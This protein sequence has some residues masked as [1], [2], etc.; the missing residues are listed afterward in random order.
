[1]KYAFITGGGR[2]LG[3]GFVEYLSRNGYYVF[4]GV[5]TIKPEYKN[6]DLVE[7]VKCNVGDDQS[8]TSCVNQVKTKTVNLN[9]IVNNAGIN[10]DSATDGHK[11]QVCTL[12]QLKR[13]KLLSMMNINAIS[14]LMVVQAFHDLLMGSPS[15]VI[16][17]S[18]DRASYHDEYDNPT[19]NYGYRASKA[20]QNMFTF[21]ST[22]DLPPNVKIFAVHPGNVKTDMNPGGSQQPVNQAEKIMTITTEWKD[23]YNGKFMRWDG[24]YYPL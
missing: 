5:Q 3:A 1:M 10:K 9:L 18:S 17:I 14:P 22:T 23:E 21:C 7:Y 8:I 24:N 12:G 6:S 15:F 11:E 2:G 19:G 16:N 4:A 20:A 13:D